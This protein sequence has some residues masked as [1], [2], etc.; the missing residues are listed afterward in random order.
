MKYAYLLET[1]KSGRILCR[2]HMNGRQLLKA[3]KSQLDNYLITRMPYQLY[4]DG[5]LWDAPTFRYQADIWQRKGWTAEGL[6][7]GPKAI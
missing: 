5:R 3:A 4:K 7:E 1:E 2:L 6:I